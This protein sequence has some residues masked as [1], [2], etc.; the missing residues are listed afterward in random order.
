[1]DRQARAKEGL[2]IV[3][4]GAG[5]IGS[6]FGA[7]LADAGYDVTLVGRH[8]HADAINRHGIRISGR[9]DRIVKVRAT[10]EPTAGGIVFLTVK[11]Y[12][13][14]DAAKQIR[15]NEGG[16]I[17]SLQNGLGNIERIV[18]VFNGDCVVGGTTSYGAL[19][20]EPGHIRHTGVGDTI[21]GG[22]TE[23]ALD[24]ASLVAGMLT[25][26]GI[27]TK[28]VTDIKTAIW[29]KLVVNAGINAPTAIARIRN[30]DLLKTPEMKWIMNEAAME[31]VKVGR[32]AGVPLDKSLLSKVEEVA[33]KTAEN[34]SSML[35]DVERRKRTEIDAIN[36]EIMRL[37]ERYGISTPVNRALFYLV[38]GVESGYLNLK[39]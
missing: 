22:L 6:L 38:K 13:T 36:G 5:A 15:I 14:I 23:N 26:A 20:I 34:R 24:K 2:S 8:A 35:Q 3:I 18:E 7:L 1:M 9:T 31:S 4:M 10:T 21:V 11:S 28:T 32:A 30:G 12:D 25:D 39:S 33:V 37:G 27:K 29:Q 16:V 19:F 17:V